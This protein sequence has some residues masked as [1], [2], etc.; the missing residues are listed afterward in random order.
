M[1]QVIGV[2]L[3]CI[4]VAVAVQAR[5]TTLPDACGDDKT[6]FDVKTAKNQ[7]QPA[8]ADPAK[9]RIVFVEFVDKSNAGLCLG[10]SF[11][12]RV[13]LDGRWVGANKG[14]S[15]FVLDVAPGEHHLCTA[16]QSIDGELRTDIGVAA[17]NAEAGKVY[18]YQ[19]TFK[20][21]QGVTNLPNGRV[22]ATGA[23]SLDLARLSEDEGKYGVKVSA[24]ATA[25]A[26]E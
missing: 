18:Y 24:L 19:I 13:G 14:N 26:R 21:T 3:A 10:C 11:T 1:K 7:P 25:T 6:Q 9:A 15:Y 17:L 5:C 22:S 2:F 12:A 16:W 4:S 20:E 8:P 23:W